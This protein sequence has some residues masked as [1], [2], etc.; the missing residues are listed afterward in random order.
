MLK[1][2]AWESGPSRSQTV[3]LVSIQ[4]ADPVGSEDGS[5]PDSP[6]L[7]KPTS[8]RALLSTGDSS[9]LVLR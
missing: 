5:A 4:N 8:P 3:N 7:E 6:V 1:I 9:Q 2:E